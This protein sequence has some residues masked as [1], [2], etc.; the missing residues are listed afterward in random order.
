MTRKIFL[1]LVLLAV[2]SPAAALTVL[3]LNLEQLTALSEKVFVGRC[4]SVTPG[5]DDEG[6]RIQDVVFEVSEILKGEPEGRVSFRQL[7]IVDSGTDF[8]MKGGAR[9]QGLDREL[10]RYEVGEEAIVFLSAPGKSGLTA[11]VGLA[12]GK[13]SVV[14]E[15]GAKGVV[16]GKGNRGLFIGADKSPKMKTLASTAAGSRIFENN[17]GAIPYA[18]FVSLVK[19]LASQ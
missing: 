8:G 19:A 10:P 2:A 17:G 3:Q 4:V 1:G 13:F 11:P 5:K 18:D 9:I 15:N 12:Q 14:A 7:G 16:N 6:R